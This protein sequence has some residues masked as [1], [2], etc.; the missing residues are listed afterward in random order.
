MSWSGEKGMVENMYSN[1]KNC[2]IDLEL[3]GTNMWEDKI[4]CISALDTTDPSEIKTFASEKEEETLISFL[5]FFNSNGF[6]TLIGF[7]VSY[8]HQCIVTHAMKYCLPIGAFYSVYLTDL[9]LILKGRRF[10][11]NQ[12][13]SLDQWGKY[14]LNQG[15]MTIEDTI[16]ALYRQGK[17]DQIRRY[18]QT[19]VR[20]T[21][22]IWQR[23]Q[24]CL[25]GQ[26]TFRFQGA[27]I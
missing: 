16:P 19:D 21:F 22:R 3:N 7:N 10:T 23:L 11:Y 20:I 2:V 9:M 14:L 27:R 26:D 6:Q 8:D 1:G 12:V 24:E 5:K 18:N 13:G 25:G 15:K 4:I 17:L